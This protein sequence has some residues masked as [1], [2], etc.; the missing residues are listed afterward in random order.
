[1]YFCLPVALSLSLSLLLLSHSLLSYPSSPSHHPLT[2]TKAGKLWGCIT[3]LLDMTIVS[4]ILP[5]LAITLSCLSAIRP[6][7]NDQCQSWRLFI[8]LSLYPSWLL[9][10]PLLS[11]WL[12]SSLYFCFF[13]SFS[14]TIWRR[15]FPPSYSSMAAASMA[16][17]RMCRR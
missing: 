14:F 2:L 6:L 1:M 4:A 17:Q 16:G 15:F 8:Y 3:D 13:L 7:L 11:F 5:C 9:T 10:A 12:P